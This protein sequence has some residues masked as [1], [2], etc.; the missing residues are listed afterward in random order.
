M[1]KGNTHEVDTCLTAGI[2]EAL[3]ALDNVFDV[4]PTTQGTYEVYQKIE[5]FL[6]LPMSVAPYLFLRSMSMTSSNTSL[7]LETWVLRVGGLNSC[8]FQF[9]DALTIQGTN[10]CGS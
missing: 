2:F 1:G 10:Q 4:F 7:F 8:K 6:G 5:R 3:L 9:C